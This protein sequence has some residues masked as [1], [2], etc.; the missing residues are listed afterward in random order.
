VP[1]VAFS[2]K[3]SPSGSAWPACR[4]RLER[5]RRRRSPHPRTS[6]RPRARSRNL[7]SCAGPP[8]AQ[9][10]TRFTAP[11]R[12]TMA[13]EN[14]PITERGAAASALETRAGSIDAKLETQIHVVADVDRRLGQID[15]GS[16]RRPRAV[17]PRPQRQRWRASRELVRRWWMSASARPAIWPTSRPSAPPWPRQAGGSKPRPRRSATLPS[18]LARVPIGAGHSVAHR[19]DGSVLRSVPSRDGRSFGTAITHRLKPHLVRRTFDC[20]RD[21]A[22]EGFSGQGPGGD[23]L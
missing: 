12:P 20:C 10:A 5:S 13:R 17:G 23:S 2:R 11:L 8:V 7:L 3:I 1:R 14:G 22:I 4:A 9:R 6:P 15:T 19:L 18:S 16:R 21:A